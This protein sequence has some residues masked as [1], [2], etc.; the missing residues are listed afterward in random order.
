MKKF[1]NI[2]FPSFA[3]MVLGAILIYIITQYNSGTEYNSLPFKIAS[4]TAIS[5]I[6]LFL[7]TLLRG[8]FDIVFFVP[9]YGMIVTSYLAYTSYYEISRSEPTLIGLTIPT[10]L[11]LL[12]A[13][14]LPEVH[15]RAKVRELAS[16]CI[17]G[18]K[19]EQFSKTPWKLF[20]DAP[21]ELSTLYFDIP[22][23]Y[24][25]QSS[26]TNKEL[27]GLIDEIFAKNF[28]TIEKYSGTLIRSTE[29]SMLIAFELLE[30]KR[31]SVPMEPK[32][33]CAYS[34]ILCA[35]EL[36]QNLEEIKASM[37]N[38]SPLIKRLKG[39]CGIGSG[40]GLILKHIRNGR[41]DLSLFTN[42]M[43]HISEMLKKSTGEDILCD[44]RTYDLCSEYFSA[45]KMNDTS[46][47][48]VGLSN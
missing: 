15:R 26:L 19:L 47:S 25:A 43:S 38:E 20:D 12:L 46:Y 33:Y 14:I 22:G 6:S 30:Q 45:Q 16:C 35:L 41:M 29:D 8:F 7:I 3:N 18:E 28:R 37:K 10:S 39:R 17:K 1:Y 24:A 44:A 13:P 48:I 5:I 31:I 34:T 21:K 32:I 27:K 4:L 23:F 40:N 36:R 42:S 9:I 11:L 2:L